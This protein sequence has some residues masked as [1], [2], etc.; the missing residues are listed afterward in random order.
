MHF[1]QTRKQF[2]RKYYCLASLK[3]HLLKFY[4][5]NAN[6]LTDFMTHRFF[7]IPQL[8]WTTVV[9]SLPLCSIRSGITGIAHCPINI[10]QY[11]RATACRA[12]NAHFFAFEFW[13]MRPVETRAISWKTCALSRFSL[14][15]TFHRFLYRFN[16]P[17]LYM[18]IGC[19]PRIGFLFCHAVGT[20][21]VKHFL[22]F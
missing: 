15:I 16:F 4:D 12:T 14:I 13:R 18:S 19:I 7:Y 10:C 11:R 9:A 17:I 22:L 6:K 3:N 20:K 8:F 2:T 5:P 21:C 1:F